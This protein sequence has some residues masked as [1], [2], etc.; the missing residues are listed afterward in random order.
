MNLRSLAGLLLTAGSLAACSSGAVSTSASDGLLEGAG[1]GRSDVGRSDVGWPDVGQSVFSA[2]AAAAD[3]AQPTTS[4]AQPAT[5]PATT[6]TAAPVTANPVTAS[7]VT[8]S[9]V[10]ASPVERPVEGSTTSAASARKTE[11]SVTTSAVASAA[12]EPPKPV[13]TYDGSNGPAYA[14]WQR[15]GSIEVRSYESYIVAQVTVSGSYDQATQR[16]FGPLFGYISG[17]N[18][19]QDEID[20]TTPVLVAS[21]QIDSGQTESEK[22]EMTA[23][24]LAERARA[25]I[26]GDESQ[27]GRYLTNSWNVA[28]VL[29]SRYTFGSAPLPT[30]EFVSLREIKPHRVAVIRFDGYLYGGRAEEHRRQL[31]EWLEA[32]GLE[33]FGD[34]RSASYDAPRVPSAQRRNEVMVTLQ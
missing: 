15:D 9:P 24:V 22:I 23:P 16:G 28:F 34:W 13:D 21:E 32:K 10:T 31:D 2:P 18:Q 8:A 29:P 19:R 30:S 25:S 20:M 12:A 6:P 7:P 27:P 11:A 14:V 1:V 33:H 3:L 17:Q 26:N 5:D 4:V